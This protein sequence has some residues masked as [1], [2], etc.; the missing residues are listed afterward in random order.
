MAVQGSGWNIEIFGNL[1]ESVYKVSQALDHTFKALLIM[2]RPTNYFP[3]DDW[4]LI[5][6]DMSLELKKHVLQRPRS[7]TCLDNGIPAILS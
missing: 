2:Q 5:P 7:R 4:S 1:F 3:R 6:P